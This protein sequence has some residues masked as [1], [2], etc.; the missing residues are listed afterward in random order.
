MKIGMTNAYVN[1]PVEAFKFYTETLGFVEIMYKP[2]VNLAIVASPQD[3]I[4]YNFNN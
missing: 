2:E 4:G 1:S 3:I